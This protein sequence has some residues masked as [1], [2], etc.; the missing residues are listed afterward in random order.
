MFFFVYVLLF[1][2][3]LVSV[4]A[5]FTINKRNLHLEVNTF[6]GL[7]R[8]IIL[9]L[10][11]L[12]I[13]LLVSVGANL[14]QFAAS[15][16]GIDENTLI[17]PPFFVFVQCMLL[18]F[19]TLEINE[20]QALKL[21]ARDAWQN[22]LIISLITDIFASALLLLIKFN[23]EGNFGSTI[24]IGTMAFLASFVVVI[25]ARIDNQRPPQKTSAVNDTQT[26]VSENKKVKLESNDV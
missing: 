18:V 5:F 10:F 21:G 1:I 22:L 19:I 15:N 17:L 9:V 11:L 2:Y 4:A 25:F 14:N 8:L 7:I 24:V 12:G 26:S 23:Q 20:I 3:F 13:P 6:D 16:K